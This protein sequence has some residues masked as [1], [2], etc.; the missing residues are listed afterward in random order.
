VKNPKPE[1][2]NPKQ[3]PNSKSKIVSNLLSPQITGGGQEWGLRSGTENVPCIVGF[4]KAVEINEKLKNKE[5]KR[6]QNLR[7]YFWRELQKIFPKIQLNGSASQ[8]LPNNLNIYFPG[9]SAH[10]RCIELDL[11]GIA[12]SPGVACSARSSK[13]SYVIEALGL[14]SDRANSSLRFTFGRQT[15]KIEIKK[16]LK[17]ITKLH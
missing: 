6:V 10:D 2:R 9:S 5:T 16:A 17:L 13:P 8:R 11:L 15:S 7:D 12:V 14:S 4:G 3:I 1:T